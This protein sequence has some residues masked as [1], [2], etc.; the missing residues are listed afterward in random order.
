MCLVFSFYCRRC[1]AATP[2]LCALEEALEP[3][4]FLIPTVSFSR[5]YGCVDFT[6]DRFNDDD[7]LE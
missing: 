7:L 5:S 2:E 3:C 6:G 1:L 4:V